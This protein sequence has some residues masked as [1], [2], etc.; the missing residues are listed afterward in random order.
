MFK[1]GSASRF[2]NLSGYDIKTHTSYHNHQQTQLGHSVFRRCNSRILDSFLVISVLCINLYLPWDRLEPILSWDP[3]KYEL[4]HTTTQLILLFLKVPLL[5]LLLK[6]GLFRQKANKSKNVQPT[7][8]PA[9][10]KNG[11]LLDKRTKLALPL[12]RLIV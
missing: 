12:C 3:S 1:T 7:L 9:Y 4:Y 8:F 5:A 11:P 6:F 10:N 2:Q